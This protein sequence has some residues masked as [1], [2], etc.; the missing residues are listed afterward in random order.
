MREFRSI[1][2]QIATGYAGG[3]VFNGNANRE[4]IMVPF[5]SAAQRLI[6]AARPISLFITHCRADDVGS[7]T[8][9]SYICVILYYDVCRYMSFW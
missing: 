5:P 6:K 3:G 2:R 8:V 7:R 4:V 1:V 9:N